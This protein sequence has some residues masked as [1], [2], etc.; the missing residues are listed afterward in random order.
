V[1]AGRIRTPGTTASVPL[2]GYSLAEAL[3][4]VYDVEA[5]KIA[6]IVADDG[7]ILKTE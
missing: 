2:A 7:K 4:N 5:K 3:S 1:P 6:F